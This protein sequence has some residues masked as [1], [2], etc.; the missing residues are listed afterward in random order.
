MARSARMAAPVPTGT[1][2]SGLREVAA[3]PVKYKA[4][5]EEQTVVRFGWPEGPR[6]RRSVKEEWGSS[7][8][9]LLSE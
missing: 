4:G 8:P 2:T 3:A 1:T 9:A 5:G 6:W 7:S